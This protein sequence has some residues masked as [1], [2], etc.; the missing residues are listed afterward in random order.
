VCD[1][2]ATMELR[3]KTVRYFKS[4]S[5]STAQLKQD[6]KLKD[7]AA[8]NEANNNHHHLKQGSGK[9]EGGGGGGASE[10]GDGSKR[11]KV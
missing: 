6:S 7:K 9:K 11:Q 10:E 5:K 1:D 3:I 8:A 2:E 4:L